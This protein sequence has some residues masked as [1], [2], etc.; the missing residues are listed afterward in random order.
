M[1]MLHL[2]LFPAF[3][4]AAIF[5]LLLGFS[6]SLSPDGLALLGFKESV[7]SDPLKLLS[8]WNPA[9]ESPCS[10]YGVSCDG[11]SGRVT[12]LNITGLSRSPSRFPFLLPPDSGDNSSVLAGTL[13][14]SIGNLTSLQVL[15]LPHNAFSGRIPEEIGRLRALEFLELQ[16]NSFSGSIPDQISYLPYLRVLNLAYNSLSGEIPGRIVKC[17]RLRWLNLEGN[18]LNGS[19]PENLIGFA[20]LESIDLSYNQLS[21]KIARKHFGQCG[22]LQRLHISCNSFISSIPREV[23]NCSKLRSLILSG[24]V[25]EGAIPPEIGLL[26]ELQIVDVSRNSLT[27]RIPRELAN[28]RKLSVLVLTNLVDISSFC[29]KLSYYS[30]SSSFRE[31]FNAFA[32]GIPY[33]VLVLPNIRIFWAPRANLNGRLPYYWGTS[34]QLRILNLGL[35][36]I[37][38]IIPDGLGMCKNL[39]FLDLSSNSLNGQLPASLPVRCMVYFNVSR[40]SLSGSMLEFEGA[41]CS[42]TIEMPSVASDGRHIYSV[43]S[44]ELDQSLEYMYSDLLSESVNLTNPFYSFSTNS[45]VILHDLSWNNFI[46]PLNFSSIGNGLLVGSPS[47][48]L[49]LNNNQFYG[50]LTVSINPTC[51]PLRGFVLDISFNQ[52]S[53]A[54]PREFFQSCPHMVDFVAAYNQ[55]SGPIPTDISNLS[56]LSNLN[57]AGNKL[58]GT[59]PDQLVNLKNL[60][61]VL[62]GEN[63]LSGEMPAQLGQS[64]SLVILNL[65]H[66]SLVG[67]IPETLGNASNI[68]VLLLDH[69]M[70]SGEIPSSFS[71]LA[72]L[73]ELD[74]S[75]NNLSGYVPA[76][77]HQINC[78]SFRGNVYLHQCTYHSSPTPIEPPIIPPDK[79]GLHPILGLGAII[80]VASS[81][82]IVLTLL[83]LLLVLYCGKKGYIKL[84]NQ[85]RK[86][87][88]TFTSN[89]VGLDYENVVRA[90]GIFSVANL[91]GT[92]GFGAT[93]KAE[94]APGFLVAVKRL[95]FGRFQGLKQFDAEIRTLGRIRHENLVTLIG[96]HMGDKETFLIY[97]YLSGG[98]LD[99]FIHKRSKKNLRWPLIR[100]IA[101]DIANALVYLHYDCVP[102][103]VHRDV[104]PSNILLDNE[105][106]AYLSDFGLARLLEVSETHATTDVAGTFGYVAPEY[107]TTCRVSD[108]ADVYSFGVVLL[109]MLSGKRSLDP[110][111][112][113]YGNGFNIVAWGNMLL[114]E[115]RPSEF[116]C[117]G[118]WETGPQ[119]KLMGM[120]KV[121]NMCSVELLTVRPSMKQVLEKLRQL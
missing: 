109:E 79:R 45:S 95:S 77:Q 113:E 69:N 110:S 22:S 84:P 98:N 54:I 20:G 58:N 89:S 75:Y 4:L 52:I 112:S 42:G 34:C 25:F 93:Y 5:L 53:G 18:F 76:L 30:L 101:L 37:D 68:R 49:L 26:S 44:E 73:L 72:N 114:K 99:S 102:R 91:I 9:D 118:L 14:A 111:F 31:E 104:K 21:G 60:Q 57:L 62:L 90:T 103:I 71:R 81:S 17:A 100:K 33:E 63:R 115:E 87:V 116:F 119:Q 43:S 8:G 64:S 6:D 106:N 55:L 51:Q 28:C 74:V 16:G 10:W 11:V 83:V 61:S 48:G 35:N 1:T 97:N 121:A 56:S 86:L 92:G 29:R 80:A 7:A 12:A 13:S 41:S 82:A 66:N 47:Y 65:S 38:G 39:T 96:Y 85:K 67:T 24:N 108:K 120:L 59:I 40:N 117:Q 46:G 23:G 94:V 88:V 32:G 107:A 2:R 19:L 36:Y 70:L 27:G 3:F 15:S 50:S 78:D 105:L